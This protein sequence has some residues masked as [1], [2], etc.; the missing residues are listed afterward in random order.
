MHAPLS[1]GYLYPHPNVAA[2]GP[3]YLHPAGFQ[4]GALGLC[5]SRRDAGFIG[6]RYR[7]SFTMAVCR[8]GGFSLEV[9]ASV[10]SMKRSFL[11][12]RLN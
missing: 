3:P 7:I 2:E 4:S 8:I 12:G 11:P 9:S 1:Q 6:A 5:L 10:A